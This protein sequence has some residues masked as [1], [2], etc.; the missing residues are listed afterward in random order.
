MMKRGFRE[1]EAE[2]MYVREEPVGSLVVGL[3]GSS[4]CYNVPAT[5][6]LSL[7]VV[8]KKKVGR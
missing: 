4:V 5:S 3:H 6:Q 2:M 7:L 1:G 8:R